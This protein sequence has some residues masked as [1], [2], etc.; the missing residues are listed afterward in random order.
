MTEDDTG[1]EFV[2]ELPPDGRGL[3]RSGETLT[4]RRRQALKKRPGVWAKWP[5]S[6]MG[7]E[8]RKKLGPG[9]DAKHRTVD[10]KRVLFVRY[11]G[12]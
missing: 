12:D 4:D 5:T 3:N 8:I 10:G 2:A 1:L 7:I 6:Q 9:F 11:I